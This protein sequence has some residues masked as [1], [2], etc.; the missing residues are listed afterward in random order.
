M[1]AGPPDP[2]GPRRNPFRGAVPRQAWTLLRRGA[3]AVAP[4]VAGLLTLVAVARVSAQPA[5]FL[6]AGLAVFAVATGIRIVLATR[7]M[8]DRQNQMVARTVFPL[9]AVA[10]FTAAFVLP[11]SGPRLEALPVAGQSIWQ[12]PTGS[13]IAYVHLPAQGTPRAAPVV[14][15]HGGPGIADMAGDASHF[16]GLTRDGFDVYVYDQAGTGHSA[17]LADLTALIAARLS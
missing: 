11:G 8:G 7:G 16:G 12:L 15:L 9:G 17:R 10:L 2:P 3:G 4:A 6:L 5:V 13:R 1:A 14:L